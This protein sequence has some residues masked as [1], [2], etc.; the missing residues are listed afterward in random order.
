MVSAKIKGWQVETVSLDEYAPVDQED[1]GFQLRLLVGPSDSQGE[2]SFD[3]TV[4]TLAWL[5]ARCEADGF[6]LG[7]HH[8][9]LSRFSAS[10]IKRIL[11]KAVERWSGDSWSDVAEKVSRIGYWEFEDYN[12]S[13]PR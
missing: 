12:D 11:V 7:R 6:V 4:C 13:E 9:I 8:L 2:E 3:L 1:F 5:A 10:A